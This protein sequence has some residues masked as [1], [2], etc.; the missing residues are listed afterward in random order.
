MNRTQI[1]TQGLLEYF[2]AMDSEFCKEFESLPLTKEQRPD[3]MRQFRIENAKKLPLVDLLE[4]VERRFEEDLQFRSGIR[5]ISRNKGKPDKSGRKG[6]LSQAETFCQVQLQ[7]LS[8]RSRKDAI[9]GVAL[10]YGKTART[11]ERQ[12]EAE[13]SRIKK[14]HAVTKDP[15]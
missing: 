13:V 14:A 7:R 3:A 10:H 1:K 8:G 15:V 12:Y 6:K 11:V 5:N 9:D 2:I 4:I